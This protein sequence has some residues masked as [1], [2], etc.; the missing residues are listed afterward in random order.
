MP[1]AMLAEVPRPLRSVTRM[2]MIG[3]SPATPAMPTPLLLRAA[4]APA[5]FVPWPNWSAVLLD[6][7]KVLAPGTSLPARSGWCGSTPLSTTAITTPG[8]P[9]VMS[10]A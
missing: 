1:L 2:G 8:A 6:L 7:S 3:D 4:A 10:H 9:C 5:I